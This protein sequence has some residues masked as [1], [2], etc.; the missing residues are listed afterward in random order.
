MSIKVAIFLAA[1]LLLFSRNPVCADIYQWT[2]NDG[3]V[4][5]TDDLQKVPSQYRKSSKGLSGEGYPFAPYQH[6]ENFSSIPMSLDSGIVSSA[7]SLEDS[8]AVWRDKARKVRAE[9]E[10]LKVKL[11]KAE[12]EHVRLRRQLW[13][14][15]GFVDD[16]IYATALDTIKELD[17]QIQEKEYEFSTTI[18]DEARRAGIPQSVV[19]P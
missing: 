10:E 16:A 8:Y 6:S 12:D 13:Y 11:R 14:Q 7:E 18:P 5:F 19:S 2:N 4:G 15:W 1:C 17:Q 9:L 3:A